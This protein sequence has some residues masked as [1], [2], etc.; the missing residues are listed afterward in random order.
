M[1]TVN[2]PALVPGVDL[3]AR[4]AAGVDMIKEAMRDAYP[5]MTICAEAYFGDSGSGVAI[6]AHGWPDFKVRLLIS[7]EVTPGGTGLTD[8]GAPR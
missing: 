5:D 2:A 1:R 3:Q 6:A 4:V 7:R 8:L